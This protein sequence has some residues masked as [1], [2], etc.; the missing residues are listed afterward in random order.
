[1]KKILFVIIIVI[2][3]IIISNKSV[4]VNSYTKS[5]GTHVKAHYRSSP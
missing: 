2:T 3:L 5:D 1:M 4:Y